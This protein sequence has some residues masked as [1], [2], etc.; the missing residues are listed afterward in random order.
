MYFL[1]VVRVGSCNLGGWKMNAQE[2]SEALGAL[3]IEDRVRVLRIYEKDLP[4]RGRCF[5]CGCE[6]LLPPVNDEEVRVIVES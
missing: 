5:T 6:R 4:S 1:W 3:S 2:V